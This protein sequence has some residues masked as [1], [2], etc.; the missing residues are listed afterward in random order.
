MTV[1]VLGGLLLIL[2]SLVS[3]IIPRR[4]V[5]HERNEMMNNATNLYKAMT[6]FA[7]ENEG[8]YPNEETAQ[9][10]DTARWMEPKWEETGWKTAEGCFAQLLLTGEIKD[11]HIF[12]SRANH[13]IGTV[14][15]TRP[16]NDGVL[17]SGENAWGYVRGLNLKDP[18]STPLFFDSSVQAG[19]FDSTVWDGKAIVA[20]VDGSVT[21]MDIDYGAGPPFE[22]DGSSK[23][24]PITEKRNGE[25]VDIFENLPK[26]AVV[27]VPSR[28]PASKEER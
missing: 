9:K 2:G 20:R 7:L 28:F 1:G 4:M 14:A 17:N 24:G 13:A 26:G 3:H 10:I 15:K 5:G 12:W 8:L 19:I 23:Q 6:S 25:F 21:S 16:E 27:L 22:E 18:M 11:E